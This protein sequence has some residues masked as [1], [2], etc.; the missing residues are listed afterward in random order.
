MTQT[1]DDRIFR[2][3]VQLHQSGQF[4]DAEKLYRQILAAN[5][6]HAPSLHMLGAMALQHKQYDQ[7]AELI[8]KSISLVPNV[9]EAHGN[10]GVALEGLGRTSDAIA[11]FRRALAMKPGNPIGH[12]KL[13]SALHNAGQ[14]QLAIAE[15]QKAISL[16]P[17][18]ADAHV[19]LG[20]TY[21]SIGQ[22]AE[23]IRCYERALELNPKFPEALSNMGNALQGLKRMDEALDCYHKALAVKPDYGEAMA[24]MGVAL[25]AQ[26]R[27]DDAID[28]HKKA[29]A[30]MPDY[31]EGY[32]NLANCLQL[33]GEIDESIRLYRKALE[34]KPEYTEAHSNL[35]NAFQEQE[36]YDEAV[37]CYRK[38]LSLNPD[39]VGALNNLGNA[40]QSLGRLDESVIWYKKAL[41]HEP[42]HFEAL[43]SLGNVLQ[44]LGKPE[45]SLTHTK[46]A[47]AIQPGQVDAYN[48]MGN[49]AKDMGLLEEA[50][51]CYR[52]SVE[53]EP[54]YY[55]VHSNAIFTMQ[56]LPDVDPRE[57]LRETVKWDE[58]QGKRVRGD[59]KPL[60]NDCDP[61]R[62]LRIGY[63]SPDFRNHCQSFFTDPLFS[64]HDHEQF[65]I[66][67]YSSVAQPDS[68]SDRLKGYA[69]VWRNV[70]AKPD[71]EIAQIIRDDKIDILIDLTMHMAHNRGLLFA[72]KPAPVQAAWLAY[73]GSTGLSTMDYRISDPFL[74]PIGLNDEYYSEKTV[75]LPDSFWCY[76]PLADEPNVNELPALKNGYITFG[77]LNN[78]C[79]IHEGLLQI[80]KRVLDAVP[81]SKLLLLV[82]TGSPRQRVLDQLRV[83]PARVEFVPF[84]SRIDYLKTYHRIDLGLDTFPVNGHTTS[85]DSL[86]MGVPVVT[87][88][89]QSAMSRAGLSQ[90]TNL[91]IADQFLGKNADEFVDLAVN[92]CSDLPRLAELRRTLRSRMEK[93]VLM[94]GAKFAKGMENLYRQMWQA[95]CAAE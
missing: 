72:C 28:C 88:Y 83:D 43:A 12:F 77:C 6:R 89:G 13:A 66:Y 78:F 85:L 26:G 62:R 18:F 5:P 44:S 63:V 32:N 39:L 51:R 48:N 8:G 35:G 75:R 20:N 87:Y 21:N 17:D 52:K 16:R 23:A 92:W 38:A 70:T 91:E 57:L 41:Q 65:E 94:D 56:F 1:V 11:S 60:A 25:Q 73:P 55:Q 64:H 84:Q 2:Q 67:L 27:I 19:N 86:W 22:F 31:A 82:P 3:A 37:A 40:L 61:D 79:K 95:W 81:T 34:L 54:T 69:D 29:L 53:L 68:V 50:I 47:L 7:A 10:L 58:M 42:E 4:A 71:A 36:K 14:S 33:K 15:F 93:S 74:D 9:S 59:I 46:K 80:W 24:N 30:M 90:T 76:N 45:E 49:A